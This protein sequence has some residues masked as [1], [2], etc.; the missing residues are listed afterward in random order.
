MEKLNVHIENGAELAC[1]QQ[2]PRN[3]RAVMGQIRAENI[4]CP[5]DVGT[6]KLRSTQRSSNTF[7]HWSVK[8][9]VVLGLTS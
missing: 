9:K 7:L 4:S 5:W 6:R 3:K 2:R 8:N 1:G